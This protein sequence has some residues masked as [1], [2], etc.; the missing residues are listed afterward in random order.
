MV[1]TVQQSLLENVFCMIGFS[2]EDPNFLSWIGW[3]HDNLG[4]SSSQKI[5]MIAVLSVPE[6]KQKMLFDKNIIVVDLEKMYPEKNIRQRLES[7][8]DSLRK[9][10]EEKENRDRWFDISKDMIESNDS[11][12]NKIKKLKKLNDTYPGWV[13]LPWSVK[14]KVN[15]VLASLEI[16]YFNNEEKLEDLS[17]DLQIDYIYEYVYFLGYVTTNS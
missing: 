14:F 3:I 5:Y 17:K 9:L 8:F 15:S 11:Y 12:E 13:F 2:C 6:V 4:K 16:N 10:I 1:N 7:F